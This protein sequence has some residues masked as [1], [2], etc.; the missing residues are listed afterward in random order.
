MKLKDHAFI[1][2]LREPVEG[3]GYGTGNTGKGVD[4]Q[5]TCGP[6]CFLDSI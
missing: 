6:P 3:T 1:W 4:I 5:R 2:K